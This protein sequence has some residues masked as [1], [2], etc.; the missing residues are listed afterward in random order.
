ARQTDREENRRVPNP[1]AESGGP[2]PGVAAQ[3]SDTVHARRGR[4]PQA[5]T[6]RRRTNAGPRGEESAGRLR[7]RVLKTHWAGHGALYDSQGRRC[8]RRNGKGQKLQILLR[9]GARTLS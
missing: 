1:R 5:A 3:G 2:A 4:A 8:P 6:R 9:A 7:I